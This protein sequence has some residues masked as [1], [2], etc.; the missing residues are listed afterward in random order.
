MMKILLA[1]DYHR[2]LADERDGGFNVDQQ[3][4]SSVLR[5]INSGGIFAVVTSGAVRHVKGLDALM[6]RLFMALENGLIVITPSGSKVINTPAD[7]WQLRSTIK[8]ALTS[9]GVK[10]SEGEASL[11]INYD[12]SVINTLRT[13][14]VRIEVNRNMVS[15]MPNGIDKGYAINVLRKMLNPGVVIAMGDAENDVPMLKAA[16]IA[17]AVN[18]AIPE[19]KSI[20]H[21][22]T[23]GND[24]DGVV[25]V[26]NK[27]LNCRREL[28][29]CII[30]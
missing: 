7:W 27:V 2:T 26:I 13:Y 16:D 24:G 11:F 22:V 12:P 25:E 29:R 8:S 5:F 6:G 23:R 9:M 1:V 10:F 28:L 17:I 19:V 18:N 14:G 3:V 4:V 21:Y 20:A 15:I 30:E